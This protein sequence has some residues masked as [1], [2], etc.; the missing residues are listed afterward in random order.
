M[1]YFVEFNTLSFLEREKSRKTSGRLILYLSSPLY[2]TSPVPVAMACR[3]NTDSTVLVVSLHY[4]H[5]N[6][7]PRFMPRSLQQA[8]VDRRGWD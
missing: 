4:I 6:K 7:V 1:K 3:Q 5:F 2:P 8:K